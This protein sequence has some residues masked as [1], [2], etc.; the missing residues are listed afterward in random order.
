MTD[1]NRTALLGDTKAR[2]VERFGVVPQSL[3]AAPA[4]V[5]LMGEHTDYASGFV[6]PAA[7]PL[8]TCVAVGPGGG[9]ETTLVST[10]FGEAVIPARDPNP[11]D[12]FA[13][14][15]AGAIQVSRI[16]GLPLQILI[17]GDMPVEAGLSSSASLVVA[18]IAALRKL[19]RPVGK[20]PLDDI[21]DR[22]EM[23]VAARAVENEHVG[24]PCGIM[25]QFVVAC[26]EADHAV[27]LDCLDGHHTH[28]RAEISGHTWLVIYSGI[29]RELAAGGYGAKVEA[30]K[31]ALVR[32]ESRGHRGAEVVRTHIPAAVRALAEAAGIANSHL[33]LLEHISA[34]NARVH[35]MRHA[36]ER[37]DASMVGTI[38]RLGHDSLSRQFGVS[39]PVIDEFVEASYKLE[40]VRGLRLT[41]AGMG[42]SLVALVRDDGIEELTTQMEAYAR[43]I[44][45]PEA[46]VVTVPSFVDGVTWR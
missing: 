40:G 7:L 30:V 4:R 17:H 37:S 28:V 20:G 13:R 5:N 16:E 39:L 25:D 46:A 19:V 14:Y 44:M 6:L 22:K 36:L 41:G 11:A 43:H 8:Y 33:P 26:A 34:D 24:V 35:L 31:A 29:R 2:F 15:L 18:T 45:S 27:L 3:A 9:D 1:P 32:L 23:A 10:E 21:E 12:G 42:G 38:L